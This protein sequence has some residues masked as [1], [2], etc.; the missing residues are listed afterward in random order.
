MSKPCKV[1]AIKAKVSDP[2]FIPFIPSLIKPNEEPYE[3]DIRDMRNDVIK[4]LYTDALSRQIF[5]LKKLQRDNEI[6]LA[7]LLD[8]VDKAIYDELHDYKKRT[9]A[10][11]NPEMQYDAVF[12]QHLLTTHGPHSSLDVRTLTTQLADLSPSIGWPKFL[13]SFN[14]SV[15][16][17]T[18][19]KQTDPTTGIVLR[20][21]KLA[22]APVP[23][24]QLT[25]DAA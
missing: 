15:T 7:I 10:T 24:Q 6:R 14:N 19:M 20:G 16:T 11:M 12:L 25:G 4:K 23:H 1:A 21:P 8:L 5:D 2:E 9:C 22:P 3:K 17:L 18:E 13:L